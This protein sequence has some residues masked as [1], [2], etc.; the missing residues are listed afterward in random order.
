MKK[1]FSDQLRVSGLGL[2]LLVVVALQAMGVR[3]YAQTTAHVTISNISARSSASGTNITVSAEGSLGGAQSWQDGEGYHVLVPG[4]LLKGNIQTGSGIDVKQLGNGVEILVQVDP[5]AGVT[6]QAS[7]NRLN[8]NVDGKLNTRPIVLND[9][10][11]ERSGQLPDHSSDQNPGY[12]SARTVGSSSAETGGSMQLAQAGNATPLGVEPEPGIDWFSVVFVESWIP[13]TVMILGLVVLV[14]AYRL[15]RKRFETEGWI[16]VV[17]E[18]EAPDVDGALSSTGPA[19]RRQVSSVKSNGTSQQPR[20]L[21]RLAVETPAELYGAYRVD[22]EVGKL[23]LGQPHRMDV[24][25]SRAPE[26][27]RAIE[28]SLLKVLNSMMADEHECRRARA[29][30]EEY[31]FVAQQSAAL[32][33]ASDPYERTSAAR[34]LG[35]M[36]SPAALPFLLESLY[37]SESIV[38]NQAVLSIGQLRLPSAI[39]ALL[40]IARKHPDVPS[41][42]L[43]RALSACS[44]EGLDFFDSPGSVS[45]LLTFGEDGPLRELTQLEPATEVED[46][47]Q[48][49]NDERLAQALGRLESDDAAERVEGIKSLTQ[50]RV[51]TAVD[52]LATVTRLAPEASL[53]AQAISSLAAINHESVFPAILIGMADES[54][55]VRAAAARSLSRLGFDRADAYVRVTDTHKS[56]QLLE[57]A[58][59]CVK[60]GIAAQAINRLAGSDR[61]QT[62]EAFA[63]ISL[64]AKATLTEPL[65]DAVMVHPNRDVRLSVI[66]LLGATCEPAVLEQ[67][68]RLPAD[69]LPEIVSNALGETIARMEAANPIT[70]EPA[71]MPDGPF[72]FGEFEVEDSGL[73]APGVA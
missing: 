49:S 12:E 66:H 9:D 4:A 21:A 2:L 63:V 70:G 38:R 8:I 64:L 43:S 5:G 26:D 37:D 20:S 16:R 19:E 7:S 53:R 28:A 33:L 39:G 55:E 27:R 48:S 44:V 69:E 40:D 58:R 30:L 24:L 61:R 60:A 29:A 1:K 15:R 3:C 47:P 71:G 10:G 65:L 32:L 67:L 34:L 35:G 68:R 50:F 45:G 31:G 52:A 62:Y 11:A 14:I 73:P 22:Q 13:G 72:D 51:R 57:V 36:K 56:E 42:L 41:T 23:V 18:S 6:T 17:K 59:A 46:L 25:S 54:R